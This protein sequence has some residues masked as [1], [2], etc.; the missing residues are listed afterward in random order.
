MAA[1]EFITL[2]ST[3]GL[4]RCENVPGRREKE[5]KVFGLSL[6]IICISPHHKNF[7]IELPMTSANRN[8]C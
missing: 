7:N 3:L 2:F 8:M 5:K 6:E 1:A 4:L